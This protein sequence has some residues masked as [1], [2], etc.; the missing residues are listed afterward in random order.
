MALK[1]LGHT[2]DAHIQYMHHAM[3]PIMLCDRQRGHYH[4]HYHYRRHDRHPPNRHPFFSPPSGPFCSLCT[5]HSSFSPAVFSTGGRIN[6]H[7]GPSTGL[8]S[9]GVSGRAVW[10]LHTQWPT[11]ESGERRHSHTL[12]ASKDHPFNSHTHTN[13]DTHMHRLKGIEE[14]AVKIR[15]L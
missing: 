5:T 9:D 6:I 11:A 15:G 13:S 10:R 4:H 8:L 7:L 14:W 2:S 12:R 1:P 3:A